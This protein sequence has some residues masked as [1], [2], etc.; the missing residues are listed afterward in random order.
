[1]VPSVKVG[2]ILEVSSHYRPPWLPATTAV[3]R[4]GQWRAGLVLSQEMSA[5]SSRP[6]IKLI[7]I[8]PSTSC[9]SISSRGISVVRLEESC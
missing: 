7:I 9:R 8:Q 2:I 5:T 3:V 6:G 1:M 4:P